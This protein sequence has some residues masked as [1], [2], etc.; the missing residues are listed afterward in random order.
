MQEKAGD[1]TIIAN[2]TVGKIV[3]ALG[4]HLES[5]APYG[6]W[7]ARADSPHGYFWGHYFEDKLTALADFGERIIYEAELIKEKN[8]REMARN[9]QNQDM[10]I[11]NQQ[12]QDK[13]VQ[14]KQPQ[15]QETVN[16]QA[17][18]QRSKPEKER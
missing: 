14:K 13:E 4:E 18:H 16:S 8:S 5:P 12:M 11:P 17:H 2:I 9:K 15:H 6:T 3:I 7:I 10:P 1:Y